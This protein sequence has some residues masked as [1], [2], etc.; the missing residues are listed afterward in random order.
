MTLENIDGDFASADLG[1][2]SLAGVVVERRARAPRGEA[3]G[4]EPVLTDDD[5]VGRDRANLDEARDAAR[6]ADQSI[7]GGCRS[8]SPCRAELVDLQFNPRHR[9]EPLSLPDQR[10][11]RAPADKVDPKAI[12]HSSFAQCTRADDA[13]VLTCSALIGRL[14]LK[15]CRSKEQRSLSRDGRTTALAVT[16]S[17]AWWPDAVRRSRAPRHLAG[18]PSVVG[19]ED[20][21]SD[22]A[23]PP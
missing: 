4:P 2:G 22:G 13:V 20:A 10:Y 11:W 12:R 19:D 21:V 17:T 7:V 15:I 23:P 14:V 16:G 5:G 3:V 18:G 1:E 8:D 9:P 6:S